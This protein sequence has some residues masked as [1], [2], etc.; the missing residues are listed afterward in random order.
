VYPPAERV[1]D[2]KLPPLKRFVSYERS[3]LDDGASYP[4]GRVED[5]ILS[6]QIM[7]VAKRAY[8]SIGGNCFGR[9]DIRTSEING[10]VYVLEVNAG[11]GIGEE[12]SSDHI[13]QL[14]N[15]STKDFLHRLIDH[16]QRGVKML[17]FTLDSSGER[18]T[19]RACRTLF[20]GEV[21]SFL[22]TTRGQKR[23]QLMESHLHQDSSSN[24]VF[25]QLDC[26][27]RATREIQAGEELFVDSATFQKLQSLLP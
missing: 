19:I 26:T 1:F 2:S 23:E 3:W 18:K 13:L 8:E 11:C 17:R 25:Y 22:R 15:Q 16:S 14:S 4:Y 10:K 12:S 24:V 9:V 20:P 21:I 27:L 7:D 6:Q 5:S